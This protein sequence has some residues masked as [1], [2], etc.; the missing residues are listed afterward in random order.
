M[1]STGSC[2]YTWGL[3]LET[4]FG[5]YVSFGVWSLASRRNSC[6]Y[7]LSVI[8]NSAAWSTE[9]GSGSCQL[10]PSPLPPQSFCSLRM[11]RVMHYLG[12][13]HYGVVGIVRYHVYSS[14]Y[15]SFTFLHLTPTL[16]KQLVT[17]VHLLS[18]LPPCAIFASSISFIPANCTT[19][20]S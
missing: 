3:E 5:N 13:A 18:T 9:L 2:V 16:P 12:S 17:F 1:S 8:L 19:F 20:S 15:T 4:L 11:H 6:S 14:L 10:L 7:A